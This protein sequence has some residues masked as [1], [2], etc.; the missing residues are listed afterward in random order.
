MKDDYLIV[1]EEPM[2]SHEDYANPPFQSDNTE[3]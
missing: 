1:D 2:E 3:S